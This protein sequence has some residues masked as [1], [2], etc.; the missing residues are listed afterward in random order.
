MIR[1]KSEDAV[2]PVIGIML[3]LVVTIIIAAVVA[4]FA[5][6]M[7]VDVEP[8]PTTVLEIDGLSDSRY[9]KVESLSKKEIYDSAKNNG[10]ITEKTGSGKIDNCIYKNIA[11]KDGT[12][13]AIYFAT[14]SKKGII[15]AY[16]DS[17]DAI[18]AR[19]KYLNS[20]TID[21][22]NKD[23]ILTLS[24][25]HGDILDLSKVSIKIS[26]YY[27]GGA[28]KPYEYEMPKGTLT[29]TFSPGNT[30]SITLPNADSIANGQSVDVT[31]YYGEHKIAEEDKLRV[32]GV[33]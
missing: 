1:K 18:A 15:E 9:E 20:V 13:F 7:T 6:G 30:L 28:T 11:T 23:R 27:K 31:V 25:L 26:Q 19:E 32:T 29:G 16:G 2:S 8:M 33:D 5:G 4:A 24:S 21:V 12:I 10:D 22:K 3:V 17:Q 14:G